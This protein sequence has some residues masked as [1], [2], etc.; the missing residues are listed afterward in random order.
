MKRT[1]LAGLGLL[2]IASA[3]GVRAEEPA[4]LSERVNFN[5]GCQRTEETPT[6]DTT[7]Y[8]LGTDTGADSVAST[9]DATPIG[10]AF[11]TAD[12]AYANV[13]T[14]AGNSTLRPGYEL[15][16]GSV[17]TGQITLSGYAGGAE[18]G[19]DSAVDVTI[20][21]SVPKPTGTG[22]TSVTLGNAE[23]AKVVSTPV[24]TVYEFT[25][26][27]PT[28]L[29]GKTVSRLS[30]DVA[31]RHVTVL[32][33]GFIDGTGGSYFDLPYAPVAE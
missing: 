29:D 33:N 13:A 30:A 27:V 3:P 6:C 15:V 17:I 11:Y 31:Q 9:F 7:E 5:I 4:L 20:S 32:Q 8:W 10:W 28:S 24:D 19:V 16:G 23:V 12:G 2:L 25:M 22:F 1:V 18:V 14:F 26:T 21:A